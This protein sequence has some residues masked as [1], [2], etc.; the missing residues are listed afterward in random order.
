MA[1]EVGC[2]VL[3]CWLVGCCGGGGGVGGIGGRWVKYFF[4]FSM[5]ML[6]CVGLELNFEKCLLRILKKRF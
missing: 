4:L 5:I 6:F 2:R 3:V 1:K